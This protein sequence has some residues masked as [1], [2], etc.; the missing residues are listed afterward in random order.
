M[1][2]AA[3][4]QSLN[5]VFNPFIHL[6]DIHWASVICRNPTSKVSCGG[7]R[8]EI[9]ILCRVGAF[10]KNSLPELDLLRFVLVVGLTLISNLALHDFF[11]HCD[12]GNSFGVRIVSNVSKHDDS[13][14][15][16][17]MFA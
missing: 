17:L 2:A 8:Q 6:R 13:I 1:T 4:K 14:I 12:K 11:V 9:L 5:R 3:I 15:N 16:Q 10:I 7:I